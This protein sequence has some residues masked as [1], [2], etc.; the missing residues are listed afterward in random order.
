MASHV[1]G[2][3]R[4]YVRAQI[5][6]IDGLAGFVVFDSTDVPDDLEIPW[7]FVWIGD[8][9]VEAFT[10]GG[11]GGRKLS[12]EVELTVDLFHR[13]KSEALA[14]AEDYC[15]QIEAKIAAYPQMGGLVKST[16]LRAYTIARS[17][18]GS[19]PI[20]RVRMQWI[21]TYWTQERDATVPA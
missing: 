9:N 16:D 7:A 1:R 11:P 19:Q 13:A 5:E 6:A 21:V 8:E 4:E 18:E 12:R 20:V 2:Q 10:L 17:E 15:A 3:I 14:L